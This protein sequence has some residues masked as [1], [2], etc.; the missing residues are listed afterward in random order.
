MH[1]TTNIRYIM[2]CALRDRLFVGL[3]AGVLLAGF[4]ASFFGSAAFLENKEMVLTL[5]ASVSRFIIVIGTIVFICFQVR[6]HF[7]NKELDVMM[8]RPVTRDAVVISYLLGFACVATLVCLPI[9]LMLAVIK[10]ISWSGFA[11]WSV[12]M[13][14][15]SWI[16]VAISLFC[17][18]VLRSA[19]LSVLSALGFYVLARMMILF[20][21]SSQYMGG[22]LQLW[23]GKKILELIS[24]MMPRLD[25]FAKSEW[26][27]YGI[28]ADNAWQLVG[29]QLLICVPLLMLA[30]MIDFRKKQF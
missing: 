22:T 19:V 5:A 23:L 3:I 25:F 27:I 15:E 16:V 20:V 12:S 28:K 10:P 8:T 26:L 1:L 2:L 17:A 29:I 24:V 4:L 11:L 30:T 18:M 14:F 9:I 13:V 6:S 21:M 7:D